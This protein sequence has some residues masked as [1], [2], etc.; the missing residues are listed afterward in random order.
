MQPLDLDSLLSGSEKAWDASPCGDHLL[1]T[2]G[3]GLVVPDIDR[4]DSAESATSI[5]DGSIALQGHSQY[6]RLLAYYSY[7]ST[8]PGQAT[9]QLPLQMMPVT[10][11]A[12]ES[13]SYKQVRHA[14][15]LPMPCAA[16]VQASALNPCSPM[17]Q[18]SSSAHADCCQLDATVPVTSPLAAVMPKGYSLQP[19]YTAANRLLDRQARVQRYQEKRKRRTFE[20]TIRYES[21]KAHAEVR[22]RIKGRFAT[23]TEV[24]AMRAD[25]VAEP[26]PAAEN[27]FDD[28]LEGYLAA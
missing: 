24:C 9:I 11:L 6:S 20:K 23:R 8:L 5:A 27:D 7:P 25:G 1:C 26:A 28:D 18:H 15:Q 12:Q 21:R 22:P 10:S 14:Q 19:C 17:E 13:A 16:D 3:T 2:A 4:T